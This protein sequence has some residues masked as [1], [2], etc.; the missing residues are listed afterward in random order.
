MSLNINVST[1]KDQT[2]LVSLEGRLDNNTAPDLAVELY[3]LVAEPIKL[4]VFDMTDLKYISSAG[5]RVLFKASKTI[6]ANGGESG[7]LKMQPQIKK[8][9]DI[10]KEFP[11]TPIF[12]DDDEIDE[13]LTVMQQ[14]VE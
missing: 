10:V 9:F 8:V 14:S 2:K 12:K 7:L 5:L 3:Q 13:Y 4:L 1:G 6:K 11:D